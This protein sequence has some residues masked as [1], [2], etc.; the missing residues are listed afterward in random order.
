[1]SAPYWR[2]V[3]AQERGST[4]Y[5]QDSAT[6]VIP[7]VTEESKADHKPQFGRLETSDASVRASDAVS[8]GE[9]DSQRTEASS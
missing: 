7:G 5:T 8:N 1:M 4:K 3:K 2:R 6:K 9:P